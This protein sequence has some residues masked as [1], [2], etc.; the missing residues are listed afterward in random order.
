VAS[1]IVQRQIAPPAGNVASEAARATHHSG[2]S[3]DAAMQQRSPR[4]E[5]K[6]FFATLVSQ[7]IWIGPAMIIIVGAFDLFCTISA[8]EKGWLVELNPVA[9]ATLEYAG[10]MGLAIYR[11]ILT[12]AGCILLTWGLRMYRLRRFV[13]SSPGRVRA[14]V[15]TGQ[16][17]LITTHLGLVAYWV[18]WL[19]V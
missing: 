19:T 16:I 1:S 9:N 18:A 8:Y 7:W 10:S 17:V 12:A 6:G 15:W 2:G 13:S 4:S 11:F 3:A 5:R 14:V